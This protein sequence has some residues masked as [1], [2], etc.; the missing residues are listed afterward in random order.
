MRRRLGISSYFFL[1]V[2]FHLLLLLL[3]LHQQNYSNRSISCDTC[4]CMVGC[5]CWWVWSLS[6]FS[7]HKWFAGICSRPGRLRS[8]LIILKQELKN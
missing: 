4:S 6:S 8:R 3:L 1:L 2:L 5:C 7:C